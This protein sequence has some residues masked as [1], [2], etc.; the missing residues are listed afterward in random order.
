MDSRALTMIREITAFLYHLMSEGMTNQ[1][2]ASVEVFGM[3]S[4]KASVYSFQNL[5]SE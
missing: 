3:A 2:A 1:G 5:R 4:S